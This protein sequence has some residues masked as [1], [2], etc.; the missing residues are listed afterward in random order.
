MKQM[1]AN[2]I[3]GKSLTSVSMPVDIFETRSNLERFAYSFGYA[4]IYLE[5]AAEETDPIEQMKHVVAFTLTLSM[6][7]LNLE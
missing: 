3:S 4:P 5:A 2:L 1:G 6:L 7:Y